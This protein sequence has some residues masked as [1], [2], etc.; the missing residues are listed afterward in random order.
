MR[1]LFAL[2]SMLFFAGFASLRA[3]RPTISPSVIYP[4]ENV[5]TI[6]TLSGIRGIRVRIHNPRHAP[7]VQLRKTGIIDGCPTAREIEMRIEV[8][9]EPV[10][11]RVYVETCDGRIDSVNVRLND[12]WNLDEVPFPDAEVGEEVCRPFRIYTGRGVYLDSISI[13]EPQASLRFSF[14]PPLRI[15]VGTTYR[16]NVCFK[17]DKPGIYKFP[18]ITWIQRRQPSGGYT[19]YPVTDTGVIRVLPKRNTVDLTDIPFDTMSHNNPV[20]VT[21]PTTFRSVAIPNAMIP[22]K[23][24]FFVGS[25]DL[26]G[27]TGG[28]SVADE[29][30][31]FAG[32]AAPLPDDWGGV[33]GDLFGAW[34]LGAKLGTQLFG[35]LNL[36]AGCHFGQSTLDKEFTPDQVDSRII[37]TVPYAAISYGTDDARVSIIGG[38]A[39]KQ[40]KRWFEDH[41]TWGDTLDVFNK[42][43]EFGAFGGDYRFAKHWKVAGEVAYMKTVDVVPIITTIRYF[44]NRFAID[45]GAGYAGIILNDADMP[46]FPILPIIS[47]V[48]VF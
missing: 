2:I 29:L 11:L 40:H 4:G 25:Y 47:G 14:P 42:D 45:V 7:F 43:V 18:V 39:F 37:V 21:D 33:N 22:P 34:S 28:Y 46:P 12:T 8:A 24:K 3:Q 5:L 16:Y 6:S 30:L 23:G 20:S 41:P 38:Y 15:E 44:T 17:A 35:K 9:S 27:L 31:V 48:F 32:V 1:L 13:P 19:N 26:L 36:A 10:L